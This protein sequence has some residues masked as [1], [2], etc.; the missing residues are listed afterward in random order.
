MKQGVELENSE[1]IDDTNAV[2]HFM[3]YSVNWFFCHC[4]DIRLFYQKQR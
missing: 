1:S 3:D 2:Y 4:N